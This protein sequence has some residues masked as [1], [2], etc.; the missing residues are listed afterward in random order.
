[1]N[2]ALKRKSWSSLQFIDHFYYGNGF[3]DQVAAKARRVRSGHFSR[4]FRNKYDFLGVHFVLGDSTV[5]GAFTGFAT[6][7]PDGA[8]EFKGRADIEFFD[9]FHDPADFIILHALIQ[10]PVATFWVHGV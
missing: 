5:S 6:E 2:I 9:E 4:S 7:Y 8:V 10:K 1:M 3:R